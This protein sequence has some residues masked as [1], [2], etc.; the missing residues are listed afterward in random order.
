VKAYE[1]RFENKDW[2]R[3]TLGYSNSTADEHYPQSGLYGMR[4]QKDLPYHYTKLVNVFENAWGMPLGQ[5]AFGLP[6]SAADMPKT[7][8]ASYDAKVWGT[9]TGAGASPNTGTYY[10]VSGTA[11]LSFN[12]G[13]GSLSGYMDTSLVGPT[14]T[15]TNPRYEFTQ[16]VYSVGSTSFSG[17][18]LVPGTTSSSSFSGQ[19]NGPQAAE[20]MASWRAPFA[21]P[22]GPNGTLWGTM[23]GV[24][25]G[26]K[27]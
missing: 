19:F 10:D 3:L 2:E 17:S 6:T 24:W 11:K 4:V 7:G 25:I 20:L 22:T 16:T 23:T 15:F 27:D 13:A 12:F 1:V 14:G 8:S 5:F 18:F 9:G 26:K 21:D